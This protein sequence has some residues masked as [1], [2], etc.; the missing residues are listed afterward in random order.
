MPREVL[1]LDAQGAIRRAANREFAER[2]HDLACAVAEPKNRHERAQSTP[3]GDVQRHDLHSPILSGRVSTPTQPLAESSPDLSG[4]VLDDRYRLIEGMKRGAMGTVY[5]AEQLRMN[6]FVAVKVLHASHDERA[7][8]RFAREAT[9]L[10]RL[11]HPNIARGIDFGWTGTGQL[12]L[13]MERIEGVDLRERLAS[14]GR[15]EWR[16][17]CRLGAQLAGALHAAHVAGFIHRDLKPE[18]VMLDQA[19]DGDQIR[20]LDFGIAKVSSAESQQLMGDDRP[21]TLQGDVLGTVGYMA[22]EQAMGQIIDRRADLYSLGVLLWEMLTGERLFD[23]DADTVLGTQLEERLPPPYLSS[24][25]PEELGALVARLLKTLP[26]ARPANAEDV[27]R[28]L[29]QLLAPRPVRPWGR[30]LA[31]GASLL[32]LLVA[33]VVAIRVGGGQPDAELDDEAIA[34]PRPQ[35]T[36]VAPDPLPEKDDEETA[37]PELP[38]GDLLHG[39]RSE[40]VAAAH[41]VLAAGD[42]APPFAVAVARLELARQCE[43]K[44]R[45]I[46]AISRYADPRALPALQRANRLRREGCGALGRRDCYACLREDLAEALRT[47]PRADRP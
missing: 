18:N 3:F 38:L 21:L 47:L 44:H 29:L 42:D 9:A 7:R 24:D 8:E 16:E 2:E 43:T 5:L 27:E 31:I 25:A 36:V 46:R 22:P 45:Q 41:A 17:V 40:R 14:G 26:D 30:W 4:Q 6:T 34:E 12:Y 13:V 23:Q 19:P 32:A 10:G 11:Q 1:V 35:F 20:V 28:E 33:G 37:E 39:R 15:F